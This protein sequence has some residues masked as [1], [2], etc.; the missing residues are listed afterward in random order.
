MVSIELGPR[1]GFLLTIESMTVDGAHHVEVPATQ[2]GIDIIRN[3]LHARQV[4]TSYNNKIGSAA[5]PT[6]NM[7]DEWLRRNKTSDAPKVP[8]E[9]KRKYDLPLDFEI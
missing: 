5:S 9:P 8:K 2:A 4:A 6:Q 7:V 1:G 3:I